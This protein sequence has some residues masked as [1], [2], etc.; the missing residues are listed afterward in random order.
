MVAVHVDDPV[1]AFGPYPPR[2]TL[3]AHRGE[4]AGLVG[5]ERAQPGAAAGLDHAGGL[6]EL[7]PGG[8]RFD[9]PLLEEVLAVEEAHRSRRLRDGTDPPVEDTLVP[10]PRHVAV[11]QLVGTVCAQVRQAVDQHEAGKLVVFDLRQVR[12]FPAV[13]EA[14]IFW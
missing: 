4:P 14:C 3:P 2:A 6:F 12:G 13:S 9:A 11:A 5:R 1:V 8:G 7:G 10:L